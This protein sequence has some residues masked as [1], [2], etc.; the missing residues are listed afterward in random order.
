MTNGDSVHN[1]CSS[2]IL[3]ALLTKKNCIKEQDIL[4]KQDIEENKIDQIIVLF[5]SS[6]LKFI[7]L[8]MKINQ[9]PNRN[10]I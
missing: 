6:W 7:L 5:E 2:K 10:Y 1:F 8:Y 3:R 9:Y 4:E